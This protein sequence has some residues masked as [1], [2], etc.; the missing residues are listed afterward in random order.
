MYEFKVAVEINDDAVHRYSLL[1]WEELMLQ[2]GDIELDEAPLSYSKV[3]QVL[4]WAL[5]RY[6]HHWAIDD[7]PLAKW[8]QTSDC[9]YTDC[10]G[11]TASTI[12]R[13]IKVGV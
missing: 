7:D 12:V 10:N 13:P 2:H 4:A 8:S 11:F 5:A 1:E 3:A 6:G 9:L